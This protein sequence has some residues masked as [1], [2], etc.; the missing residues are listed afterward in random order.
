MGTGLARFFAFAPT[1]TLPRKRGRE[2]TE[3]AD[4]FVDQPDRNLLQLSVPLLPPARMR[5][6]GLQHSPI[7]LARRSRLRPEI[8]A[9]LRPQAAAAGGLCCGPYCCAAAFNSTSYCAW[10]RG[11]VSDFF[12][13]RHAATLSMFMRYALHSLI[14]SPVQAERSSAD[15]LNSANP[16]VGHATRTSPT[17]AITRLRMFMI[18]P[19]VSM[20]PL[21]PS[22]T[23]WRARERSAVMAITKTRLCL[24]LPH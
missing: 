7:L 11:L 20:A 13:R 9:R 15:G 16:A 22:A 3:C 24:P 2:R 10:H 12:A 1:L 19:F 6:T 5:R 23:L 17:A 4:R 18:F 21:S 8:G 14:A